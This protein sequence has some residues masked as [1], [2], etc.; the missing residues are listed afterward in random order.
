MDQPKYVLE[1]GVRVH[2]HK[3]LDRED[4]LIAMPTLI[5]NRRGDADG[6]IYDIVPGHGGDVYWVKH[7]DTKIAP[8][9]FTEFEFAQNDTKNKS[10]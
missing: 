9:C 3:K 10:A 4:G 8:Y 1:R 5:A 6:A 7:A 2:T